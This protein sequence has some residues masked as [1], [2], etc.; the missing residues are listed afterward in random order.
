MGCQGFALA[1]TITDADPARDLRR[2]QLHKR[3][4]RTD[5]AIDIHLLKSHMCINI[6]NSSP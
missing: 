6:I 5:H 2:L 4:V 3:N 1:E